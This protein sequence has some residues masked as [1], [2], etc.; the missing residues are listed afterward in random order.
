MEH[1]LVRQWVQTCLM[2]VTL[3]AGITGCGVGDEARPQQYNQTDAQRGGI[4]YD[5]DQTIKPHI[6][7]ENQRVAARVADTAE[8]LPGVSRATAIIYKNHIIIGI[9]AVNRNNRRSLEQ[10]VFQIVKEKE[11]KFEVSVTSNMDI[12][13]QI[14]KIYN[15]GRGNTNSLSPI[16]PMA[17]ADF[18]IRRII[19]SIHGGTYSP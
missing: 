7:A 10:Q 5:T 17:D 19:Q 18:Q 1:S 6:F 8:D 16:P 9:D 15:N 14:Q 3:I 11:P 2:S 12:H 4:L 13:N